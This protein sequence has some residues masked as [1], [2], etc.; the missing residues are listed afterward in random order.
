MFMTN[1]SALTKLE[2]DRVRQRLLRYAASEPG[3]DL[4]RNLSIVTSAEEIRDELEAVS[5]L[6]RLLEQEEF[7]IEGVH[8]VLSPVQKAGV[9][10]TVLTPRELLQIGATLR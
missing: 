4:I 2:F 9:E 8:P 3:A 7:V 6:K 1:E 5:E 10:G